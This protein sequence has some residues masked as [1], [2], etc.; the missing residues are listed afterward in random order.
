MPVSDHVIEISTH[1]VM[2]SNIYSHCRY[3]KRCPEQGGSYVKKFAGKIAVKEGIIR[4]A[5]VN[6]DYTIR[7]EPSDTLKALRAPKG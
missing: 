4:A 5:D 7:P 3:K 2:R 1:R 6:A